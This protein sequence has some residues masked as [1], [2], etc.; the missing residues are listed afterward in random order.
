MEVRSSSDSVMTPR[1]YWKC[2]MYCPFG[3]A[4]TRACLFS[5]ANQNYHPLPTRYDEPGCGCR[6]PSEPCISQLGLQNLAELGAPTEPAAVATPTAAKSTVALA[7]GC[8]RTRF[9]HLQCTPFQVEPVELCDSSRCVL[10]WPEL[11]KPKTARAAGI[12]V[13]NHAS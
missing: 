10:A 3:S 12:H 9:V 5:P 4:F 1:P 13:A 11:D 7:A 2:L 6:D 8:L